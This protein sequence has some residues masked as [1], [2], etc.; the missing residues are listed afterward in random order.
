MALR[1]LSALVVSCALSLVGCNSLLGD[2]KY[3]PKANG[4][5]GNGS[6]GSSSGMQGDIVV[7]PTDGLVTTEQGAKATL[8]LIHI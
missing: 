2:F 1:S 4:N 6:G 7:M 5:G 8:S 3:D